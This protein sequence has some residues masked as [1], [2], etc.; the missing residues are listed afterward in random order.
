[1]RKYYRLI[2]NRPV[3][4]FLRRFIGTPHPLELVIISPFIGPMS[5]IN[6]SLKQVVNKI[7]RDKIKTLIITNPPSDEVGSQKEAINILR[8]SR[9]TEIRLLPSLH[10][11]M[12]ICRTRVGTTRDYL[13]FGSGNLTENSI[14]S[15]IEIGMMITNVG[16]GREPFSVLDSWAKD[17][18]VHPGS[19]R[20]KRID[21]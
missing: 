14:G 18:R 10:A 7:D 16:R 20:I 3:E 8:R 9:R 1:M 19:T 15:M 11:K 21:G 17:L 6:P 12:Y 13:L 4:R 2:T 5:G